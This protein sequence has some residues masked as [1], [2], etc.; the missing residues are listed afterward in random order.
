LR[1]GNV[2]EG[3]AGC[4]RQI[5]HHLSKRRSAQSN[6]AELAS[7]LVACHTL[8]LTTALLIKQRN[9]QSRR[10]RYFGIAT[11]RKVF[12]A[13][14]VALGTLRGELRLP[15]AP[16]DEGIARLCFDA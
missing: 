1:R 12:E 9:G 2:Y 11:F 16:R 3:A 6:A 7:C 13:A 4:R 10:T 15:Y 8:S 14:W 5:L